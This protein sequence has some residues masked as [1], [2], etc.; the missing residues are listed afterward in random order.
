[1]GGGWCSG[2]ARGHQACAEGGRVG[3][4]EGWSMALALFLHPLG[5]PTA[6]SHAKPQLS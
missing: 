5:I 1:M 4:S 3:G 6:G 2:A